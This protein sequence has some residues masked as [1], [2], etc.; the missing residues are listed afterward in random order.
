MNS[1]TAFVFKF[2]YLNFNMA[3]DVTATM[4]AGVMPLITPRC[5]PPSNSP[6][7]RYVLSFPASKS[8]MLLGTGKP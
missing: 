3:A 7:Q 4:S 8:R 6:D 2:C 1:E 5:S